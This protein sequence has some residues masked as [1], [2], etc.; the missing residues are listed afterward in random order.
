MFRARLTIAV[1][2]FL[3]SW[4]TVGPLWAQDLSAQ[5]QGQ[6]QG[7]NPVTPQ[8][9]TAQATV[10]PVTENAAFVQALAAALGD[11]ADALSFYTA[12]GFAPLWTGP[13]DADRRAALFAALGF[14]PAHGLPAARYDAR[15]LA[16]D[17]RRAATEG[18]RGRAEAAITRAYLDYARDV[19]AGV[20]RNPAKLDKWMQR[21]GTP[22]EPGVLLSRIDSEDAASILASLPPQMPEYAALM[23]EKAVL[24][25]LLGQDAWGGQVPPGKLVPGDQGRAVA[26]LRDRLAHLG[27]LTPGM[28]DVY[29]ADL[30]AAVKEFQADHGLNDDGVAGVGTISEI[31]MQPEDRLKSVVVA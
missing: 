31:N 24:E 1:T 19:H 8:Q 22:I 13:G 9:D 14:A 4:A 3:L 28:G 5:Y 7:Q 10:V 23:R 6:Y 26:A 25:S 29:D 18:D 20:V 11:D 27:Y 12:R 16:E 30:E 17:L 21:K 2:S 15:A